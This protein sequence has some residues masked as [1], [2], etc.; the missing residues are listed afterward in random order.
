MSIDWLDS[1]GE[2]SSAL[3]NTYKKRK[4]PATRSGSRGLPLHLE[5]VATASTATD[6]LHLEVAAT[7]ATAPWSGSHHFHYT[8]QWQPP[9]PLH[10][11]VVAPTATTPRSRHSRPG[12]TVDTSVC[13]SWAAGSRGDRCTRDDREAGQGRR[14]PPATERSQLNYFHVQF[15]FGRRCF[16]I[17]NVNFRKQVHYI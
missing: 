10:L 15:F 14:F 4:M 12:D 1:I 9:L 6:P 5:V 17:V 13:P 16:W 8:S 7:T 11:A 2:E 3:I